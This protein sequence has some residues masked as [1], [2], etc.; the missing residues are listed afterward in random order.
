MALLVLLPPSEGKSDLT[1][2]KK[3][4]ADDLPDYAAAVLPVI[5]HLKALPKPER[6]KFYGV[7][8]DE[9]AAAAHRLNLAALEAVGIP[10]IERYTGVVYD[11]LDYKTLKR[12]TYARKHLLIL[13]GMFGL[14]PAG[15][16]IPDYKLPLNAWLTRYWQSI[17]GERLA[18]MRQGHTVVSLLPGAHA[19]ALGGVPDITIDFR[20]AGGRKSAGHFGKAIKGKFVRF[21]MEEQVTD[22]K[23]MARFRED[24]YEFDGQNFVQP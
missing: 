1:V 15:A 7:S 14:I 11:H 4:F 12:P 5:K 20:Q 6:P 8:S 10:A 2:G 13:S 21:L 3:T 22:L 19:R 9:K 24:G 17:N 18:S 16:P 23:G